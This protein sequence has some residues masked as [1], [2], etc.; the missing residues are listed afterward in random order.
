MSP[1]QASQPSGAISAIALWTDRV[2]VSPPSFIAGAR[3]A[4]LEGGFDLDRDAARQAAHPDRGAG[5][6]AAIAEHRDHQVGGAVDHLR[7][8]GEL[9]G[10][11][12]KS[13]EAQAPRHAVEIAAAGNPQM[14]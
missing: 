6:A 4:D 12:D 1:A 2:M 5:M 13:A 8:V 3:S 7:H 11:V 9:R 14:R 10:A